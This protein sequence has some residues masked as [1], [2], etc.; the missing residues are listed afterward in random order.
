MGR[1]T[2]DQVL[3]DFVKDCRT[4]WPEDLVSVNVYGSAA[5]GDYDPGRSDINTLIVLEDGEPARLVP[6]MSRSAGWRKKGL[7]APLVITRQDLQT[8]L[9]VFPV[10]FLNMKLFYRL[11]LGED[12]LA[13]LSFDPLDI[14]RECEREFKGKLITLRQ[15]FLSTGGQGRVMQDLVSGTLGAFF[16]LFRALLTLYQTDMPVAHEEV[17]R[18]LAGHLNFPSQ[19][20]LSL[21][22][23]RAGR[24]KKSVTE[25]TQLWQE[26]LSAV[27]ALAQLI[28]G[29]DANNCHQNAHGGGLS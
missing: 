18:S 25:M 5:R 28:D 7:A 9:D 23:V 15:A 16:A 19:P 14:R 27:A 22:E 6:A 4:V 3:A 26:Y 12:V 2:L 8:S 29:M 17:I 11:L 24:T 10:E 20:F 21:A 1:Q 13:D